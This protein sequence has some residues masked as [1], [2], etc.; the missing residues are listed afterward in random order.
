M[1]KELE[2]NIK[3][4]IEGFEMPYDAQAWNRLK[5]SLDVVQP[6]SKIKSYRHLIIGASAIVSMV[7]IGYFFA[8][9]Q[10][11][12]NKKAVTH[13][14]S[15]TRLDS[16]HSDK[17]AHTTE[18]IKVFKENPNT[19]TN[20]NSTISQQQNENVNTLKVNDQKETAVYVNSLTQS[21]NQE[22][23]R[24]TKSEIS[25]NSKFSV[26]T[27][28]DICLGESVTINNPNEQGFQIRLNNEKVT[29]IKGNQSSNFKPTQE[30]RYTINYVINGTNQ[31]EVFFTVLASPSADFIVNERNNFEHGIPT[32]E[33]NALGFG[34]SYTWSVEG[35][36]G[37][38]YGKEMQAHFFKKGNYSVAL[39]VQG[40]NG[41][42]S[43]ETKTIRVD[44]EYNLMAVNTFD[45]N[46]SDN[47]RN[48]F[49]PYAL[50]QLETEFT[51]T[52]IDPKD[53]SIIFESND[54]TNPWKGI[55]SR[56]NQLVN[57]GT[58]IWKVIIKSPLKGEKSAY[59]GII[60][61]L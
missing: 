46:T 30:G 12:K 19:I 6:A 57:S 4:S 38:E 59:Q 16:P 34:S 10:T 54:A 24:I 49:M 29:Y 61:R 48:S 26:P 32:I 7:V 42:Q 47:K 33:L 2:H 58:Y 9:N 25:S 52:I 3:E 55:D 31:S 37:F 18:E 5:K 53:G 50:T 17:T 15:D 28:S 11:Q 45:P 43:K 40:V 8:N 1:K 27:L 13:Q 44:E 23:N 56:T 14:S 41:C 20:E 22:I 21:K 39:V 51:L 35:Q 60:T 36:N